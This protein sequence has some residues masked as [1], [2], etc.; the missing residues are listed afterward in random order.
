M[1]RSSFLPNRLCLQKPSCG[2]IAGILVFIFLLM[3]GL[4]WAWAKGLLRWQ[5][6]P[7]QNAPSP[8]Q[9]PKRQLSDSWT[10]DSKANCKRRVLQPPSTISTTGARQFPVAT[11]LV[12]PVAHRNDRY[13]VALR[14][15]ALWSRSF[16]PSPRQAD[17]MIVSGTVTKKMAPQ[18]V[19][20]FKQMPSPKYVIAM[21]AVPFPG[22][23]QAGLQR[24]EGDRS[25]HPCRCS[26]TRMPS[27]TGGLVARHHD[28]AAKDCPR[29]ASSSRRKEE[30]PSVLPHFV[31]EHGSHDHSHPSTMSYGIGARQK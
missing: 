2:A 12:R 7:S 6:T 9:P 14:P 24:A 3:E 10:K 26:Y 8:T 1:S 30:R 21:G 18:V 25:I 16:R 5:F 28:P 15:C 31:P 11:P 4:V 22:A 23:F 20:L 29:H 27:T 17:L 13:S 19:R